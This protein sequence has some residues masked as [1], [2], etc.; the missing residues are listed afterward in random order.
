MT[1]LRRRAAASTFSKVTAV[2][3][4]ASKS[5]MDRGRQ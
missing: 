1:P 3:A 5:G 2:A 4:G